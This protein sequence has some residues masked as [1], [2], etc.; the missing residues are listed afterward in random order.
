MVLMMVSWPT[1]LFGQT[2]TEIC[3]EPSRC[4]TAAQVNAVADTLCRR[5][6]AKELAF[7][8][9]RTEAD[10]LL[11]S[12]AQC[13]GALSEY[14]GIDQARIQAL[15]QLEQVR[16]ERDER[17][18]KYWVVGGIVAGAVLGGGVALLANAL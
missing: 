10:K 8:E 7:D 6:R 3:E 13:N 2:N 5:A 4:R 1:T 17:V 14:R 9:L 15:V 18:S 11:V 16:E 12:Q